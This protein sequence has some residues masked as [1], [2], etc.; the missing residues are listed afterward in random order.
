MMGAET[1]TVTV[2]AALSAAFG[3]KGIPGSADTR[4]SARTTTANQTP[5]L[6]SIHNPAAATRPATPSATAE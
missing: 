3:A 5:H 1:R 2:A 4:L 6:L